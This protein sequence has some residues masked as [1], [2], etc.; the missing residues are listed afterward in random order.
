LY[1]SSNR[2]FSNPDYEDVGASF[3]YDDTGRLIAVPLNAEV[4][5]P[6]EIEADEETWEDEDEKDEDE[7]DKEEGD[8]QGE[9]DEEGEGDEADEADA[10]EDADADD[11]DADEPSSPIHGVWAGTAKGFAQI[12]GME[13]DEIELKLTI[14]ARDDGTCTATSESRGE[15]NTHDSVTFEDDSGDFTATRSEGGMTQKLEGKLE[16]DKLSGTWTVVEMSI[17][18]TWEATRTDEEPD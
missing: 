5:D 13:E 8:E 3:I 14:I 1:Y 15:P 17:S 16:G 11:E 10:D 4:E 18:G 7:K 6:W 9:D 2:N 12:P